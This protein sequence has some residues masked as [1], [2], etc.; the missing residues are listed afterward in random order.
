MIVAMQ[1]GDAPSTLAMIIPECYLNDGDSD[2]RVK[3]ANSCM[4]KYIENGIIKELPNGFILVERSTGG[5]R[6]RNGLMLALDL[7]AYDYTENSASIIR[8][9]EGTIIER[10]PPRMAVRREALLDLPHILILIDDPDNKVMNAA[11]SSA[12]TVAYD[13]DLSQTGGHL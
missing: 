12:E 2:K 4:K 6:K 11:G 7:E 3:N 13:S 9:T 5:M 8:P 10:L 1:V